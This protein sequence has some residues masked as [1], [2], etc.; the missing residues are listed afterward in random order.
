[1]KPL[2][3]ACLLALALVATGSLIS[4]KAMADD[5]EAPCGR[6]DNGDPLQ[7]VKPNPGL[8]AEAACIATGR[9][10]I[11]VPY[12][13]TS[14]QIRGFASACRLYDM[15]RNCF[16]GDPNICNFYLSMLRANTACQLDRNQGACDWL[17]QQQF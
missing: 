5:T 11:C 13:Q 9:P 7:C 16:G 2:V 6:D 4:G 8:D 17:E 12:H 1:M 15:G 3:Y 14:C 10:E